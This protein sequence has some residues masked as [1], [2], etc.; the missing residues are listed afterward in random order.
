MKT[1]DLVFADWRAGEIGSRVVLSIYGPYGRPEAYVLD[2]GWRDNGSPLP[3]ESRE[4]FEKSPRA[5]GVAVAVRHGTKWKPQVV[6]PGRIEILYDELCDED[7][8]LRKRLV[9]EREEMER[10]AARTQKAHNL[11]NELRDGGLD[12]TPAS[13]S[14]FAAV[15]RSATDNPDVLVRMTLKQAKA[16]HDSGIM[17]GE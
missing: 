8:A 3:G 2:K 12:L 7:K 14:T 15:P 5:R 4:R 17:G 6:Q 11:I 9:K 13:V 10:N 1:N 16:L